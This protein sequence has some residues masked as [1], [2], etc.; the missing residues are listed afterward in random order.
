MIET[1]HRAIRTGN[2]NTYKFALGR[3][4]VEVYK[5]D[6]I[7]FIEDLAGRFADYYYKNLHVFK[8]R[9]T[10]NPNQEPT[11]YKILRRMI[12]DNYGELP[13]PKRMPTQFRND[14][15]AK[16]LSPSPSWGRSVF[17]YVLPCWQGASKDAHGYYDYPRIGSNDFFDYSLDEG[18][19]RL[20]QGFAE[21]IGKHRST[22][23]ALVILEW[24]KFLE[25]FNQTPNLVLK[26]DGNKPLRRLS[27]FRKLFLS[28]PAMKPCV[29][30]ICGNQLPEN[31]FTLDHVVP[32]DFVFSDEIWNLIPA[33]RGCNSKKGARVGSERMIR[34]LVERNELLWDSEDAPIREWMR[35]SGDS[36][37]AIEQ[38]LITKV[39]S[40]LRA[41]FPQ[42]DES[43]FLG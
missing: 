24:V 28:T 43:E 10:N 38:K 26:L 36:A 19:L 34:N 15:I 16:L 1:F 33:H 4:I 31:D 2:Q 30:Q 23:L 8:L 20:S 35:A 13:A 18:I 37:V 25:K 9:E 17:T 39:I 6:N 12:E 5:G 29:C 42:V 7:L 11:A 41:G 32:F 3:A 22:L 40:A 14:Y 21:I 27:R